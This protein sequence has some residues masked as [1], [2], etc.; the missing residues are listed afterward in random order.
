MSYLI[1]VS[2]LWA[3]SP[4][5]I[6]GNLIG[7]DSAFVSAVRLGLAMLVFLPFLRL[8]R[9]SLRI[10]LTLIGIGAV[11]FGVMYL[12]YNESFHYLPAYAVA[13]FT[14]TTPIFVTLFADAIDQ[15]LRPRSL[16]AAAIA[17][18]GT[19]VIS[20]HSTT[21]TESLIRGFLLVQISNAAFA[22][23]QIFYRHA[24]TWP[25]TPDDSRGFA[26]LYAGGFIVALA[27]M[28]AKGAMPSAITFQQRLTLLYLGVVASGVGFF[29][30]NR[31][32][33]QV[34]A[35]TLAVMNNLKIPLMI[36]CSLIFFGEST[37]IPRLLLSLTLLSVALWVNGK[38]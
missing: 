9:I 19:A 3:F 18:L 10:A 30:W 22:A 7:L 38:T 34:S 25:E 31:G 28:L 8:R 26:L 13:L 35:G 11:Q 21:A 27:V 15:K 33:T 16:L 32:A 24:R 5:L 4:G 2:L 6:K 1:V 37:D 20:W 14:I 17:V 12:A 23:G 29:L 36:A